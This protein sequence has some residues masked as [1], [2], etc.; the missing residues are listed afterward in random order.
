M[1]IGNMEFN[2]AKRNVNH[3][4]KNKVALE[5]ILENLIFT[6]NQCLHG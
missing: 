2:R 4:R 5:W 6:K 1:I 3:Y